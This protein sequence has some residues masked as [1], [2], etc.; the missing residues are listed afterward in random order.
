MAEIAPPSGY[1]DRVF[2]R[3][4]LPLHSPF[5]LNVFPTNACNLKCSYC[6]HS[7]SK[8]RFETY[9]HMKGSPNMSLDTF[10]CLV[11]QSQKFQNKFKL[12][13]FMG[14]GEPLLNRDLPE[15]I[16]IAK[17]A[18]IA[19]RIEIITNG[20]LLN[21]EL[22]DD[23]ID[24]GI[25]NVRVSLQGLSSKKYMEMADIKI[26]FDEY[27]EN[28]KYFHD[29]GI[30]K[31]AR[32]FVKVLD[33]SLDY[34][35]EK[36]FYKLFEPISSRMFVEY[37]KPVYDGVQQ[38]RGLNNLSTDRYGNEHKKR[39]VCPLPFFTLSV[40]PNG[41]V[42]PCDAIYK[43][44]LLGNVN[45]D[46][47]S[48]L[49]LGSINNHFRLRLL[50]KE[51]LTMGGCSKCCA[52]DDVSNDLDVLDDFNDDLAERY[53]TLMRQKSPNSDSGK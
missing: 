10:R 53:R 37:V 28:L 26:D 25:T 44:V 47:L 32:L 11:A 17:D 42:A 50:N 45:H 13:S 19:Q 4:V 16:R 18:D 29:S 7:M 34:G 27:I 43:P 33:C 39:L 12:F 21:K 3:D 9:P 38:T 46:D 8:T 6:V 48:K 35:E 1:N 36:T 24:A 30:A 52:P 5:T 49:F 31:G 41:D 20:L 40:W 2:L 14:H 23:I 22:S 51:K 15:M